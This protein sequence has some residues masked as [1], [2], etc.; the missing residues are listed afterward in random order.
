MKALIGDEY[1]HGSLRVLVSRINSWSQLGEC[2]VIVIYSS[3][4]STVK[5]Y[6]DLCKLTLL[7]V[8]HGPYFSNSFFNSSDL[9]LLE[10]FPTNKLILL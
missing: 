6:T 3:I 10:R 5:H 1:G 7:V 4:H 8:L 2:N 9:T